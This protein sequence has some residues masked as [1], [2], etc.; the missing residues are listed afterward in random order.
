MLATSYLNYSDLHFA[1]DKIFPEESRNGTVVG[2]CEPEELL[3]SLAHEDGNLMLHIMNN[4][5][6]M[7]EDPWEIRV[8]FSEA[9]D[10]FLTKKYKPV[11]NREIL[12]GSIDHFVSP[13]GQ[14]VVVLKTVNDERRLYFHDINN[15]LAIARI[16]IP[17]QDIVMEEW[18]ESNYW[19]KWNKAIEDVSGYVQR[20]DSN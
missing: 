10:Q 20:Q 12:D 4:S 16:T 14:Y 17:G 7:Y 6:R 5:G 13:D 8:K 9:P 11:Q 2:L 3:I 15:P 18:C 19:S 1:Y